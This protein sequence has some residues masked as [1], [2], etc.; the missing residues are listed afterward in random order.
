MKQF[1]VNRLDVKFRSTSRTKL[2]AEFEEFMRRDVEMVEVTFG[3]DEY[4]N[5]KSCYK[6]LWTHTKRKDFHYPVRVRYCKGHVYLE[7]TDK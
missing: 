7:R 1:V 4:V 2:E 5:P 3:V 6:S